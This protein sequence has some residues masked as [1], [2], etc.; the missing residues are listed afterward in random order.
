MSRNVRPVAVALICACAAAPALA[1]ES[2]A[3][4]TPALVDGPDGST[5]PLSPE[6]SA[7]LGNALVFD[8]VQLG[9][10]LPKKQ[11]RLPG[12][13]NAKG[14]DVSRTDGADG[15]S[16]IIL[17][18]PLATEWDAK[19]GADL[20]LAPNTPFEF[21]P[22][23]PLRVTRDGAGSGA[24]WASL[25]V[26]D[27]ATVDARVD[28]TN[29]RGRVGTTFTRSIP[30]SG[31]FAVTLQSSYSVTETFGHGQ[32]AASD[33]PLIAAPISD[34][35]DPTQRVWGNEN[36]AKFNI[37]GTGTTLAAGLS[38]TS[39]DPVTHNRL[40]AEQKLYGPLHVTTA[41]SDLGRESESKSLSAR[42]KLNW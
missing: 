15:S 1:Q 6:D 29:D 34:P 4:E 19:V 35:A 3:N 41:V 30:V 22:S 17:N 16:T 33:V 21:T 28:P 40:S 14:L 8:P 25:G 37:L 11:L 31:N 5:A 36:V 20:G 27:L 24:A 18:K 39:T 12:L 7:L 9:G 26:P 42:F 32:A 38:A 2:P 13:S 23:N 10:R